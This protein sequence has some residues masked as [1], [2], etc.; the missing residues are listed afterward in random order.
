M[1]PK[2][3]YKITE[4]LIFNN[5]IKSINDKKYKLTIMKSF[6]FSSKYQSNSVVVHNNLDSSYR[7]FIK[8]SPEKIIPLCIQESLPQDIDGV[9]LNKNYEGFRIFAC[10]TKPLRDNISEHGIYRE[11]YEKDLIFLGLI[12]FKN[13]LKK[14][15]KH[16]IGKLKDSECEIVIATGDN[17]FNTISVAQECEIINKEQNIFFIKLEKTYKKVDKLSWYNLTKKIADQNKITTNFDKLINSTG[18]SNYN[19]D[20]LLKEINEEKNSIICITG[21]AFNYIVKRRKNT[22]INEDEKTIFQKIAN[23]IS[24]KGKIFSRMESK[25]K[26]TLVKFLKENKSNIVAM[27]S[28]GAHDCGT[29]LAA[30]I[31]IS[32]SN[33]KDSNITS[34]FY[35]YQD[36]ISCIETI[37]KNGRACFEN[38]LIIFKFIIIYAACQNLSTILFYII[39][40]DGFDDKLFY[41]IDIVIV[42]VP[43][44]LASK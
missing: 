36:S 20:C 34:H 32:I 17:P 28:D 10:A 14:D 25:D 26:V 8:G 19:I 30:D 35:S 12:L 4:E 6:D 11:K 33:L 9:L 16:I 40:T 44:L 43:S 41:I 24:Q 38:C 23:S 31:G 1:L 29:L 5:T 21:E 13:K 18:T 27:C 15:T 2:N 7:F 37:L 3:N 42:L 22:N 39:K